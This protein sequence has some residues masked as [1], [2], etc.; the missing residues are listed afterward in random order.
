MNAEDSIADVHK[1]SSN[2]KSDSPDI[3]LPEDAPPAVTSKSTTK[4]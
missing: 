4:M 2:S 3:E 1:P